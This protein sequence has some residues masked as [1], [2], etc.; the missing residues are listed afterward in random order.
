MTGL[1]VIS[2]VMVLL[3]F[4]I[5]GCDD[6]SN[7]NGPE[8]THVINPLEVGNKSVFKITDYDL[9]GGV[10]DISYDT[11]LIVKDTNIGGDVWY[12]VE[13]FDYTGYNRNTAQGMEEWTPSDECLL[14]KYPAT[15]GDEYDCSMYDVHYEVNATNA[16]VTVEH[17][18]YTCYEYVQTPVSGLGDSVLQYCC[19]D[20]GLILWENHTPVIV[21]DDTTFYLRKRHELTELVW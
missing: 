17:G 10:T 18:T 1:K 21:G 5:L 16:A 8:P 2:F 4:A 14:L 12:V 6:D 20:T 7:S 3:M 19:V 13:G 11:I 15:D 9:G